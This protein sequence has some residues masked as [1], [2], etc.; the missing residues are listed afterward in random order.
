MT[1]DF[2]TRA[3]LKLVP[4]VP[5]YTISTASLNIEKI[6]DL[7]NEKKVIAY[8]DHQEARTIL[9]WES[10]DYDAIGQ[11]TDDDVINRIKEIY[12]NL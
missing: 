10:D 7:P 1:V 11:W 8:T 12:E 6:E 3:V 4:A 2:T 9:L 5:E